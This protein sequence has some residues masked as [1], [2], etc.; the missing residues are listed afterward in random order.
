MLEALFLLKLKDPVSLPVKHIELKNKTL[1]AIEK[2]KYLFKPQTLPVIYFR[3]Y[4]V[5]LPLAE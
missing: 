4:H 2:R 5:S 1:G 3:S